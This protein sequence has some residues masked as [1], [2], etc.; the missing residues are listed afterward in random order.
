MFLQLNLV[1]LLQVY[2]VFGFIPNV[3]HFALL[4]AISQISPIVAG[5][6]ERF[7]ALLLKTVTSMV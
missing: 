3:Y 5:L 2:K 1:R 6:T 4:L 7:T